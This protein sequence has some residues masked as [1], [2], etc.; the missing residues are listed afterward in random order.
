MIK[1]FVMAEFYL[2]KFLPFSYWSAAI[3]AK[4]RNLIVCSH[5]HRHR[6]I[7]GQCL[8]YSMIP[9]LLLKNFGR[10]FLIVRLFL[11]CSSWKMYLHRSQ[12]PCLPQDRKRRHIH[13]T[14]CVPRNCKLQEKSS[15]TMLFVSTITV[16]ESNF[17]KIKK[18]TVENDIFTKTLLFILRILFKH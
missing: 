10:T 3:N 11:W 13:D 9:P 14:F 16:I 4:E 5:T 1:K 15:I 8:H 12:D 2:S 17:G 18:N 6:Q 7:H